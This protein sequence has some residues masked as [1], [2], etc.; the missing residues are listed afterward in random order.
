MRKLLLAFALVLAI[1]SLPL[2]VRAD[3]TSP[4]AVEQTGGDL[5]KTNVVGVIAT[6]LAGYF[7]P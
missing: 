2:A 4:S 1:C 3:S 6:V 7:L 5:S